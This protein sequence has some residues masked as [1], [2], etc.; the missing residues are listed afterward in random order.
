[1]NSS[2]LRT[3]LVIG[4]LMA[5]GGAPR[6][7]GKG[8]GAAVASAAERTRRPGAVAGAGQ[9]VAPP[10]EPGPAVAGATPGT[11]ALWHAGSTPPGPTDEGRARAVLAREALRLDLASAPGDLE[12]EASFRSPVGTHVRFRQVVEG[13][14]VE[15]GGA[16]VHWAPDGRLLLVAADLRPVPPDAPPPAL[17]PSDARAAA[18]AFAVEP[19]EE[20]GAAITEPRLSWLPAGRSARLAFATTVRTADETLLVF[21]DAATGDVLLAED[22]RR[23]AEGSGQVFAPNPVWTTRDSSLEDIGDND[24]PVLEAALATV[25]LPRLDG[26]GYLRGTWADLS[27]TRPRAF[28]P[29]LQFHY[30]RSDPRFELVNAYFHVDAIQEYV[31][32]VLGFQGAAGRLRVDAHHGQV[33]NSFYDV[34]TRRLYFGDGGV[35]DAEDGDIVAH[36]YGHAL[37]DAQVRGFGHSREAGAMGEGF[38]D[39]IAASRRSSGNETWDA[40]VGSWDATAFSTA[41]PPALRRVDGS[42]RYPEDVRGEVHADGEIWSSALWEIRRRIGAEE[43]D[44]VIIG[45]HFLLTPRATFAEGAAAVVAANLSLRG[46]AGEADLRAAFDGR[47]I[48]VGDDPVEEDDGPAAA[49]PVDRAAFTGMY[50]ADDD[51]FLVLADPGT[52]TAFTAVSPLPGVRPVLALFD[53]GLREI[54][55]SQRYDATPSVA[56][57]AVAVRTPF[58]LRVSPGSGGPGPYDLHVGGTWA[59]PAPDRFEPNGTAETAAPL[60]TGSFARIH[61]SAGDEDWFVVEGTQGATVEVSATFEAG[62]LDAD[63]ALFAP[64]GTL[65]AEAATPGSPETLSRIVE[66]VDAPRVLL[67]ATA[68]SGSGTADLLVFVRPG[69]GVL[70]RRPVKGVLEP[71]REMNF[72]LPVAVEPGTTTRVR[73]SARRFGAGGTVPD[74]EV[75]SPG[76]FLAVPLGAGAFP[77]GATVEFEAPESGDWRIGVR[78]RDGSG[79]G[80]R[81]KARAR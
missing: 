37:Q 69:A 43:A 15:G 70:G 75:I 58:L 26:T 53:E 5:G 71:A 4:V 48:P 8:R 17:S 55:A 36:E 50:A 23:A 21:V 45:S 68:A 59:A 11:R 34:S 32:S 49:P 42:S 12:L 77:G 61:L 22:L 16:S 18:A 28:E 72:T 6:E 29:S 78:S 9:G 35:D 1:M 44:R 54:A 40:A 27:P 47:G 20:R 81:L 33:D 7:A 66:G 46:G 52:G 65:L 73:V 64:D 60:P 56:T 80:F 3:A 63:L 39:Y 57:G 10:R 13:V 31:H 41:F 67:R 14:P 62:A 51:W 2:G 76:G 74:V 25:P 30:T 38:G 19:G 24:S 79:G